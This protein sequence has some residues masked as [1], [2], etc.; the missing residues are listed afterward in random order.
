MFHIQWTLEAEQDLEHILLYYVD[1]AGLRVAE[2]VYNR[3][4][5]QVGRLDTFPESTRP[6]RVP[7]TREC[8]IGRLPYIAVIDVAD[9]VVTVLS[10]VHT[11]REFPP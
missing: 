1:Q 6:G 11:A 4:R 7:G 5:E 9:D 8:V 10:V 2:A 3:I